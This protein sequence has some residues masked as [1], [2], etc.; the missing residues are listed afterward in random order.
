MCPSMVKVKQEPTKQKG[1]G[2]GPIWAQT[3]AVKKT[4]PNSSDW[5]VIFVTSE[6]QQTTDSEKKKK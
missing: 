4:F 6:Q 5:I 2:F 1:H 3:V